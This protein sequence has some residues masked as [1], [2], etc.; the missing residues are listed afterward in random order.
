MIEIADLRDCPP[1]G[2]LY[3]GR[4]GRKEGILIDGEPWLA[5]YPRSTRDLR[6]RGL[7]SYTSSPLSE[8]L[9]SHIYALL[10]IPTH[11]TRLGYRDG[12]IV[13]ACRDFTSP[14]VVLYEFSK[15]KTTMDDDAC[16][17]FLWIREDEETC[18]GG[19]FGRRERW[20]GSHNESSPSWRRRTSPTS[21]RWR[22]AGSA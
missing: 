6:G 14:G 13:C 11:E 20:R 15:V 1:S 8:Y 19:G 12:K 17:G 3:G 18:S 22:R 10:G 7:P 5:K 4:A 9:G 21:G 16:E 2:R